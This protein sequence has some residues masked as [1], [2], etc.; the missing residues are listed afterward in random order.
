M[1]LMMSLV[2]FSLFLYSLFALLNQTTKV[3]QNED[4]RQMMEF[5][6]LAFQLRQDVKRCETL[7]VEEGTLELTWG[8]G[9]PS[10]T[11]TT[12]KKVNDQLV[13]TLVKDGDSE[14]RRY[15]VK[16]KSLDIQARGRQVSVTLEIQTDE[17]ART[18]R[19]VGTRL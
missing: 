15:F 14:S 7:Q 16:A 3:L 17:G 9:P 8:A 11:E 18:L 5:S 12:Y 2:L 6:K 10:T 19:I 1:E 13:R 4:D